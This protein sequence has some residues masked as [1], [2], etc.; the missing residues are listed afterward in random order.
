M[1]PAGLALRR[2]SVAQDGADRHPQAHARD[3][4]RAGELYDLANDPQE[5]DNRF[6]DPGV[7]AAQRQLMDMIARRPDD[8]IDPLPQIGMA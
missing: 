4:F 8:K 5:M 2:R 7:A 1:G 6:G 3:Q